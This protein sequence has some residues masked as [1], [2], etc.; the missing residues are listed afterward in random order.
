MRGC[1]WAGAGAACPRGHSQ[2]HTEPGLG[3]HWWGTQ[4][5]AARAVG[6]SADPRAALRAVPAET[7]AVTG[8][9]VRFET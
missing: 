7:G 2:V 5:A 4:G 6:T 9:T 1:V 8:P 3:A